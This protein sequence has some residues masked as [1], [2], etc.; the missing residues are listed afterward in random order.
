[1]GDPI[2]PPP[3][4]G[5]AWAGFPANWQAKPVPALARPPALWQGSA[6]LG[7][8]LWAD[9]RIRA[10]CRSSVVEH[11]IGNGEVDSSILSGSTSFLSG[12][13]CKISINPRFHL[14]AGSSHFGYFARNRPG[15]R[16]PTDTKLARWFAFCPLIQ[17]VQPAAISL[18]ATRCAADREGSWRGPSASDTDERSN[19]TE[20]LPGKLAIATTFKTVD[21][22]RLDRFQAPC[23]VPEPRPRDLCP[24]SRRKFRL[25]FS[26]KI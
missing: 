18:R 1:M 26:Q 17:T 5:A 4:P 20:R 7:G 24:G 3:R 23:F 2:G 21:V 25:C 22:R 10:C 11:S 6:R 8:A 19:A 9:S 12:K 14:A 15:K 16:E 13:P